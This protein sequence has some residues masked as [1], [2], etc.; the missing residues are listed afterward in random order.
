MPEKK[1]QDYPVQT[2]QSSSQ[3]S[4]HSLAVY[5]TPLRKRLH[6][7]WGLQ[8]KIKFLLSMILSKE[9]NGQVTKL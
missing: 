1:I 6:C 9:R 4:T 7:N 8:E 2:Y 5:Y 3:P